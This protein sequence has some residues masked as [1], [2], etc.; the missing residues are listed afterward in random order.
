MRPLPPWTARSVSRFSNFCATYRKRRGSRL[1]LSHTTWPSCGR[2]VI[3]CWSCTWGGSSK[4][5]TTRNCLAHQSTL[6]RGRY[7]TRCPFPTPWSRRSVRHCAVRWAPWSTRRRAAC[8]IRVARLPRRFAA[9]RNRRLS[10]TRARALPATGRPLSNSTQR[11]RDG[12]AVDRE[13][14]L[15]Q[16]RFHLIR[17]AALDKVATADDDRSLRVGLNDHLDDRHWNGQVDRC[18][19]A[20]QK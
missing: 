11:D 12:R 4:L 10:T 19:G 16:L 18:L 9:T 1:S 17:V 8:F 13:Q 2:S 14:A 20:K 7:S 15:L 6:T 5:L 3:G